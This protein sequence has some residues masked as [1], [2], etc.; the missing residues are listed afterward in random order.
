MSVLLALTMFAFG[1]LSYFSLP[2][3]EL[4]NVNFPYIAVT[5][6]YPGASAL[7]MASNVATPLEQSFQNLKGLD[8]MHSQSRSGFTQVVLKFKLDQDLDTAAQNVQSKINH[9][10]HKL[11][12]NLPSRPSYKKFNP[13]DSPMIYLAVSS[14][15]L[16]K[17]QLYR[18]GT[19]RVVKKLQRLDGVGNIMNFSSKPAI[20]IRINPEELTAR[21]LT[22]LDVSE[23]I[24]SNNLHLPAGN[25]EG[26]HKNYYL[27]PKGQLKSVK[28]YADLVIS[29]TRDGAVYLRDVADVVSSIKNVHLTERQWERGQGTQTGV[30]ELLIQKSPG[31]NTIK[32][33]ERIRNALPDIKK[34]LPKSLEFSITYDGSIPVQDS[35][36][37][38]KTTLYIAFALVVFVIFLFLGRVRDTLIPAVAL[39]ASFMLTFMVMS[40][41]GY[42]LDILSMMALTLAVG[43]LVDDAIVVLENTARHLETGKS[44]LRAALDGA[45]EITTTVISMTLSLSAV[46]IPLA[47]MP[48]LVGKIFQ[49]FSVVIIVSILC[50]GLVAVT[51]SP[52]MCGRLLKKQK[53]GP[54]ILER[55]VQ[56]MVGSL[57][58]FYLFFLRFILRFNFLAVLIWVGCLL[59]TG[60]LIQQLPQTFFPKGDSGLIAGKIKA[61]QDVS[62]QQMQVLQRQVEKAL[63]KDSAVNIV[64]T[65][66]GGSQVG[67]RNSM[68]LAVKLIDR[69]K[70]QGIKTVN[71]RLEKRLAGLPGMDVGMSPVPV[72]QIGGGGSGGEAYSYVLRGDHAQKLY[73]VADSFTD[74]VK[75]MQGLKDVESSLKLNNPELDIR[76]DHEKAASLGLTTEDIERTLYLAYS[77]GK[78]TNYLTSTDQYKVIMGMQD[79]FKNEPKML[80]KIYLRPRGKQQLV[81]LSEVCTWKETVGPMEVKHRELQNEVTIA[82]NLKP[83]VTLG[84]ITKQMKKLSTENI[85]P[86]IKAG[87]TGQAKKFQKTTQSMIM[88][89]GVAV[90]VM[91]LILGILYESYIHP[92]TVLTALPVACFGGIFSLWVFDSVFS[93][94]SMLGLFMLMGIAKKNGIMLVDFA[95]GALKQEGCTR[96]EAIYKA[97]E[98]RFRPILMTGVAA[99]FGILPVALGSGADGASRQPLGIAVAGG[100]VFSQ[101]ITLFLTPVFYLYLEWF[102]EKVLYRFA[103]FRPPEIE[104]EQ[105]GQ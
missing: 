66:V 94:Y 95:R 45:S 80:N 30:N 101:L 93:I 67:P 64:W 14:D 27:H 3:S 21:G 5:C 9:A 51:L 91:Y 49:E 52:A 73:Q 105:S 92:I 22:L 99:I 23:A 43:F 44:P 40:S 1:V 65:A 100:L 97:C 84:E 25:L 72:L 18:L 11:P 81:P 85:P 78:V 2:V 35:I 13:S 47:F 8:S 86:D 26:R 50:S 10:M 77:G 4:P 6:D 83:N 54:G 19:N 46:F 53:K 29:Y 57:R 96:R 20:H 15:V 56:S 71:S 70:R 104:D 103:F 79:K 17:G 24:K 87:F 68:Y 38:V 76:I 82:F 12:G 74:K 75:D 89:L 48:G 37:D 59:G 55:I 90:L 69:D 34:D 42:N 33:A 28:D 60:Y 41:L 39:P 102:Q 7:T 61:S 32:V 63:R 16:T 58:K 31:A 88:L 36:N 62:Y 98:A